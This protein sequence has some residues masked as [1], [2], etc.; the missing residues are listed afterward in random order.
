[1]VTKDFGEKAAQPKISKT[2]KSRL[3]R[4]T[5]I[6]LAQSSTK[7]HPSNKNH[8]DECGFHIRG[9]GHLE[10]SH[11]LGLRIDHKRKS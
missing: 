2:A 11:H 10:G 1:M 5:R 9:E 6:L 4:D 3:R 7:Y 8:C